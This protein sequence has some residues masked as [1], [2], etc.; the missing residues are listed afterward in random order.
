MVIF[1]FSNCEIIR[2]V[3]VTCFYDLGKAIT[4][5]GSFVLDRI[6]WPALMPLWLSMPYFIVYVTAGGLALIA[7][8]KGIKKNNPKPT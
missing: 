4:A 1:N 7:Y 5:I 2:A 8:S 6:L 3:K